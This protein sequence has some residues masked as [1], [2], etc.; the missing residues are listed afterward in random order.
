LT[1]I[2]TAPKSITASVISPTGI[3]RAV[4]IES[5]AQYAP[6]KAVVISIAFISF[7]FFSACLADKTTVA[8]FQGNKTTIYDKLFITVR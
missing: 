1:A 7:P 4:G 5:I 6:T 3:A 2:A 8:E